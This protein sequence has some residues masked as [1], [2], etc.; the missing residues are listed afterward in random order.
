MRVRAAARRFFTAAAA[1]EC[2][3]TISFGMLEGAGPGA[4]LG[5]SNWLDYDGTCFTWMRQAGTRRS[6]E[7]VT[8]GD[9]DLAVVDTTTFAG[10]VERGAPIAAFTINGFQSSGIGLVMR[11]GLAEPRL[12]AG[13]KIATVYRVRAALE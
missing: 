9:L 10:A 7:S 3:K 11:P 8:R 4:V 6:L 5:P 2:N 13:A 12:L 1:G